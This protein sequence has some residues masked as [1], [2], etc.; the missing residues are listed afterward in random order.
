MPWT[1]LRLF[2]LWLR[3]TGVVTLR[4]RGACSGCPSSSVTLKSGV[5]NMLMHYIPEVVADQRQAICNQPTVL[6]EL[7]ELL[8]LYL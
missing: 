5:E 1:L 3:E 6:L 2:L 7:G 4:M 8:L